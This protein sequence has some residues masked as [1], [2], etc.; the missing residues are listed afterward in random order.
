[1]YVPNFI[2]IGQKLFVD[3]RTA[4]PTDG[5]TDISPSNVIRSTRRSRPKNSLNNYF[6]L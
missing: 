5:R 6:A 2:E 3:G 1:M 4:V